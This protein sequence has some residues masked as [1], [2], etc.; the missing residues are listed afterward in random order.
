MIVVDVKGSWQNS[1]QPVQVTAQ[2]D[3]WNM[4][5]T[6]SWIDN[7]RGRLLPSVGLEVD[8]R[9]ASQR[10]YEDSMEW[11]ACYTAIP[12]VSSTLTGFQLTITRGS[13]YTTI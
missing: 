11:Y 12:E 3:G 8:N 4:Q 9:G 13:I 6:D 2:C 7:I 5:R 10:K 1:P